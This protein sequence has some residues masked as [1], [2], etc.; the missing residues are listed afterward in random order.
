LEVADVAEVVSQLESQGYTQEFRIKNRRLF[1]HEH[2]S[3]LDPANIHVDTARCTLSGYDEE[4]AS[5]TYG[6][7]DLKAH[8]IDGR[9]V[10]Y[11]GHDLQPK[12][13]RA[14]REKARRRVWL[15]AV[16]S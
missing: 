12:I 13:D 11:C 2:N 1:D 9:R 8:A 6:N 3:A 10:R 4:D 7:S 15:Y 14:I 5:I 16:M